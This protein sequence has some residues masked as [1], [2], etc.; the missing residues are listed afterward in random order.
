MPTL[1]AR[2]CDHASFTIFY[3]N[4]HMWLAPLLCLVLHY[5][6]GRPLQPAPLHPS[7]THSNASQTRTRQMYE[8]Y[9]D[10]DEYN[11]WVSSYA[12]GCC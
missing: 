12:F 8:F 2:S 10:D 7:D 6:G 4:T 3:G 11:A 5:P 9:Y 1:F